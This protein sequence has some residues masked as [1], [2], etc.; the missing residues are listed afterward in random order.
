MREFQSWEE[1]LKASAQWKSQSKPR[2]VRAQSPAHQRRLPVSTS[3]ALWRRPWGRI[4]THVPT[5]ELSEMAATAPWAL[6]LCAQRFKNPSDARGAFLK[7]FVGVMQ[8]VG[9]QAC[10]DSADLYSLIT[11]H[12][13]FRSQ[14]GKES[15]R[16]EEKTRDE[17]GPG[18]VG[19]SGKEG[20]AA[21][22]DVA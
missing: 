17:G 5:S 1:G 21:A 15:R 12:E 13:A 9:E 11:S 10:Q 6:E 22:H 2:D 16:R 14:S 19:A 4:F 18:G 3:D 8:L 7:R 20:S